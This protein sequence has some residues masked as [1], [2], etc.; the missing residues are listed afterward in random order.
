MKK[1]IG[2]VRKILKNVKMEL[3]ERMDEI[4]ETFIL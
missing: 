1:S 4:S 2:N 3:S